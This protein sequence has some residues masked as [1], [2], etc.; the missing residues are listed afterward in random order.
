MQETPSTLEWKWIC[1]ECGEFHS[2]PV[3]LCRKCGYKFTEQESNPQYKLVILSGPH[4]G[5]ELIINKPQISLGRR[6]PQSDWVPDVDLVFDRCVSRWHAVLYYENGSYQLRPI[7]RRGSNGTMK[8]P[9]NPV[10]LVDKGGREKEIIPGMK[11][12]LSVGEKF[13]LGPNTLIEFTKI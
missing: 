10:V 1:P 11:H 9:A 2:N 5:I 12:T 13:K 6:D 3:K 7:T 4:D 8:G